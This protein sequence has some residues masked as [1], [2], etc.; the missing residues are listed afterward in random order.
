MSP[1]IFEL[2]NYLRQMNG[3]IN[4]AEF[5]DIVHRHTKIE[6]L[7]NEV[8]D[9]FKA[10]DKTGKG[11]VKASELR[12]LLQNW[13]EVLGAREVD[14]IFR[15]ANVK[16]DGNI[17]YADFVKIA[18]A[19]VPDYYWYHGSIYS[20]MPASKLAIENYYQKMHSLQFYLC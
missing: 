7:P 6:N 10:D 18:C 17:Q 11:L 2:T 8:I 19:P 9:A 20:L 15:E 5:L 1:T 4:F 12:Y 3:R 13:G 14:K 16:N